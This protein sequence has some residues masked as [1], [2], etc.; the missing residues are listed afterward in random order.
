MRH[1]GL[2]AAIALFA[3]MLVGTT[4]IAQH[5]KY[6]QM[7]EM[8]SLEKK[9]LSPAQQERIGMIRQQTSNE[10]QKI[11]MDPNLTKQQ[12]VEKTNKALS[13]GHK[14]VMNELTPAQRETYYK[15]WQE[16]YHAAG[17]APHTGAG[18][19]MVQQYKSGQMPMLKKYPLTSEQQKKIAAI[20]AD[21]QSKVESIRVDKSMNQ[22]K[23]SQMIEQTRANGQKQVMNVLT[24]DQKAE[25]MAWYN[26]KMGSP[27][28]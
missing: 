4:A 23:K 17:T 21:T 10:V 26:K 18:P 14:R 2:I 5:S 8:P 15:Y 19:S 27:K 3:S 25:Y 6:M 24:P 20:R 22:K 7:G 28:M 13:A 11:Q 1:L 12:K 16:K 9:P